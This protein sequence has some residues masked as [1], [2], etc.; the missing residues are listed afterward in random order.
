MKFP[1]ACLLLLLGG[2]P[3]GAFPTGVTG[4]S[5]PVQA[6]LVS[7]DTSVQPGHSVTLALRFVHQPH[8]HTYWVYPGT[9]LTTTIAW[10]LPP[11]WKAGEIQWPAPKLLR[12]SRNNV[13][14]NGYDGD[15]L[16]PVTLTAPAG[17]APGGSVEIKAAVDWLMCADECVP[18]EA[19]LT[20]A[21]GVRAGPAQADPVWG[22]RIRSVLA[23]LPVADPA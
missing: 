17:L 10:T 13:V 9:G 3:A 14:G 21:L 20:L 19:S 23:G 5:S 7:A 1:V 22:P 8:W 4:A 16:L 11:G 6:S 15:L 18:G 2:I 12:D